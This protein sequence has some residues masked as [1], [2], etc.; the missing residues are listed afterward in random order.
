MIL[1]ASI[2]ALL[3]AQNIA[4]AAPGK[5][6][7]PSASKGDGK[8]KVATCVDGKEYWSAST[9]H[10]GACSGHGGVASYEDGSPVK[11]R[12]RKTDYR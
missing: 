12:G 9:E 3:I 10:R 1:K 4:F 7:V 6:P 8:E 11:S 5:A 2:F